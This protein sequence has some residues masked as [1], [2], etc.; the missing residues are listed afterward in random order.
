MKKLIVFTII[1]MTLL[2]SSLSLAYWVGEIDISPISVEHDTS[3]RIGEWDVDNGNIEEIRLPIGVI[4]GQ[5][6][7]GNNVDRVGNVYYFDNTYYL[8]NTNQNGEINLNNPNSNPLKPYHIEYVKGTN[9]VVGDLVIFENEVYQAKEKNA[10][11]H[12]LT[13]DKWN[14][15]GNI[16]NIRWLNKSYSKG[17]VVYHRDS[18]YIANKDIASS[19]EPDKSFD[20]D[21]QGKLLFDYYTEYK[22][23]NLYGLNRTIVAYE[24]PHD[25]LRLYELKAQSNIISG[26]IILPGMDNEVW[27]PYE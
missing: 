13:S 27:K 5:P 20:W 6:I 18:L 23:P 21:I 15:L 2:T 4:E 22:N 10:S 14:H 9:Y 17:S 12:P 16:E 26:E 11:N 7:K 19:L 1:L 3:V 24:A 8:F 25:Q